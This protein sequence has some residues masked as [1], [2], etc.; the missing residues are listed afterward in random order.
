VLGIRTVGTELATYLTILAANL[1]QLGA[2]GGVPA[3]RIPRGEPPNLARRGEIATKTQ[4]LR[5]ALPW[6]A[7]RML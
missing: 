1:R 4:K 2:G 5:P 7:G 3:E 6:A